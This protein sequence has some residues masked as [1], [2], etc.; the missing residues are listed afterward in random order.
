L[1]ALPPFPTRRSSDLHHY[2]S[3]VDAKRWRVLAALL[4]SDWNR[5]DADIYL[6][7]RQTYKREPRGIGYRERVRVS[8]NSDGHRAANRAT[9]RS[10]EHTS[11]LQS[12]VEL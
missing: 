6:R 12:R 10:E 7:A 1:L 2:Q 8:W 9:A 5:L 3:R 11:E 4:Y